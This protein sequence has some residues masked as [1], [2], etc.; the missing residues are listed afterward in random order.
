M[1]TVTVKVDLPDGW[2]LA[3]DHMRNVKCGEYW[4][5]TFGELVGPSNFDETDPSNYD[6]TWPRV[7]VRKAWQ[8]PEWLTCAAVVRTKGGDVWACSTV[9][10]IDECM[11]S[12]WSDTGAVLLLSGQFVNLDYPDG[13]WRDS[14]RLNPNRKD[15]A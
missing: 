10:H 3:C 11:T 13:P 2:E 5:D 9:P 7:I 6:A 4:I 15:E 14:R 8:W 12:G 1:N